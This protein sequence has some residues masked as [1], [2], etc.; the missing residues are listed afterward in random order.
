MKMIRKVLVVAVCLMAANAA[1]AQLGGFGG[2]LG[3]AK[4]GAS[5]GGDI[6]ADVSTF[7]TK[8]AALSELAGVSVRAINA[9]FVSDEKLE[10]TRAQI[11]KWKSG[12]ARSPAKKKKMIGQ[13]LL[14]FGIGTL[15]AVELT[16]NGQSLIQK[17][18]ASRMTISAGPMPTLRLSA[19]SLAPDRV[20]PRAN[21]LPGPAQ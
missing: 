13:A 7:V 10:E 3:A 18:G 15:Q 6:S 14:N 5:P 11:K 16:K 1:N 12:S 17:A 19:L 20:T 8:S 21:F 4:P 9:A 2:M